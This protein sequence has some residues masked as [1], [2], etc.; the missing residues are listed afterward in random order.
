[1]SE[2]A[3]EGFHQDKRLLELVKGGNVDHGIHDLADYALRGEV[4][5]VRELL[6]D[7]DLDVNLRDA[8]TMAALHWAAAYN[9]VRSALKISPLC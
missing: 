1:M 8:E 2:E 6:S 5:L 4:K 9:E 3:R 7:E